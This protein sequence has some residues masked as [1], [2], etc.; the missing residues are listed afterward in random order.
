MA[1]F[2]RLQLLPAVP[3]ILKPTQ[4]DGDPILKNRP[5]GEFTIDG[6][7]RARYFHAPGDTDPGVL[8]ED[9]TTRDTVSTGELATFPYYDA[10][11]GGLNLLVLV[12]VGSD[13]GA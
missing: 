13:G 4:A 3:L 9:T 5:A 6:P 1:H 11:L 7:D 2:S 10:E 12:A 8:A